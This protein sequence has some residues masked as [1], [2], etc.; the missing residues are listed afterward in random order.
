M[1][2]VLQTE[3]WAIFFI[4]SFILLIATFN[5]V[6]SVIMIILEKRKDIFS[7]RSIGASDVTLAKIFFYEGLLVTLFGAALG[8]F[9]GVGLCL[10]QQKFGLLTLG[11]EGNF[12][13]NAYP[14]EV[15]TLD[16]FLI[17]LTV[18]SIGI[19]VTLIPV[20]IL[21]RKFIN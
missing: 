7:L 10:L 21:K 14:V 12:I 20:Q 6:A 1:Y 17:M 8:L 11:S 13:V 5:I 16:I 15:Q 19:V 3:K 18:V 9:F 2:K 4:L